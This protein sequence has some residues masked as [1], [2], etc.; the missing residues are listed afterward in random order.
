MVLGMFTNPYLVLLFLLGGLFVPK[1]H[2]PFT[3]KKLEN[4]L[5]DGVTALAQLSALCSDRA[6][7]FN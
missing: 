6:L 4:N 7:S 5:A 1:F 2:T 3:K